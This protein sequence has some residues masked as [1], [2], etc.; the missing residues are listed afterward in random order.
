[1]DMQ[2]VVM[3]MILP[4]WG[5]PK[6]ADVSPHITNILIGILTNCTAG[7]NQAAAALGRLAA[8]TRAVA[9]P[10]PD[11]VQRI[12]EMGFPADSAREA[13]RRV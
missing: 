7:T 8:G 10:N 1:M 11:T 5:H 3:G 13:L 2:S 6:L 9:D 4:L 12:V